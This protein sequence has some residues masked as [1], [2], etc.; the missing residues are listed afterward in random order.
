MERPKQPGKPH[1]SGQQAGPS[2]GTADGPTGPTTRATY[3]EAWEGYP[4]DKINE[5]KN[6]N[7]S[8][9]SFV[10]LI[11]YV[12]KDIVV[13]AV[14]QIPALVA[15]GFVSLDNIFVAGDFDTGSPVFL[16]QVGNSDILTA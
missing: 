2:A 8:S 4:H 7:R 14:K 5:Q 9:A 6:R 1:I 13:A 16:Y 15:V 3:V 10:L 11:G 12:P